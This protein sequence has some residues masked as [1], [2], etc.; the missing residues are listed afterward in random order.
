MVEVSLEEQNKAVLVDGCKF[1]VP[2]TICGVAE[3]N[4]CAVEEPRG[5]RNACDAVAGMS[6]RRKESLFPLVS[7]DMISK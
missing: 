5:D 4:G 6:N 2:S 3:T 1:L 7:E